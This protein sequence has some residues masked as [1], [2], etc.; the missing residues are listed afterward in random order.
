M[1]ISISVIPLRF[2]T[3]TNRSEWL[4]LYVAL[5]LEVSHN[6]FQSMNNRDPKLASPFSLGKF[7]KSNLH[8]TDFRVLLLC[9]APK[10][11]S[12]QK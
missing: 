10:I 7:W 9:S 5:M 11:E 2:D 1:E 6:M 8:R 4:E 3:A 12:R